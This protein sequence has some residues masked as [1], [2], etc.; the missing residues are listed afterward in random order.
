MESS[1]GMESSAIETATNARVSTGGVGPCRASMIEAAE[2]AGMRRCAM[3][4]AVILRATEISS[5]V[6]LA[7]LQTNVINS[8]VEPEM[9]P[10][11]VL[12]FVVEPSMVEAGVPNLAVI[13]AVVKERSAVGYIDA[14]VVQ[15]PPV[16]P[17][18]SPGGPT[19]PETGEEA[20]SESRA[21]VDARP[22]KIDSRNCDPPWI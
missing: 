7:M 20:D 17:V 22:V 3:V 1:A 18:E 10:V 19:P 9:L 14:M 6:E 11:A 21:E 12:G 5:V 15:H 13:E 8:V 16:M 2:C 4:E